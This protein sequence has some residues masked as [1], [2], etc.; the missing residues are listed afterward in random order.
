MCNPLDLSYLAV[1]QRAGVAPAI[2]SFVAMAVRDHA[3]RALDRGAVDG[4]DVEGCA[5][6]GGIAEAQVDAV[7]AAM[8]A[9]G[10]IAEG[11]W[12]LP[13]PGRRAPLSGA[14]RTRRCRAR[15]AAHRDVTKNVT[16]ATAGRAGDGNAPEIKARLS[17]GGVTVGVTPLKEDLES[18]N[19]ILRTSLKKMPSADVTVVVAPGVEGKAAKRQAWFALTMVPWMR[20]QMSADRAGKLIGAWYTDEIERDAAEARGEKWTKTAVQREVDELDR[21]RKGAAAPV[22]QRAQQREIFLPRVIEGAVSEGP[23]LLPI[24]GPPFL[25][26]DPLPGRRT[27]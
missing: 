26:V 8:T 24:E 3:E 6:W 25:P 2:A 16:P 10:I 20:A 1:A 21:V 23:P 27:A 18:I 22:R 12:T 14:E 13:L 11:R 15:A 19:L 7:L 9:K 5:V 17:N 4:F